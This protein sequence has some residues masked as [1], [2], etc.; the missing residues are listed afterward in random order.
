[1]PT[2]EFLKK[3]LSTAGAQAKPLASSAA[4][5]IL[6]SAVAGTAGY[7]AAPSLSDWA[8]IETEPG[9]LANR[10]GTAAAWASAASPA[11]RSS[12][13]TKN[14]AKGVLK[15]MER[16]GKTVEELREIA[17]G[18]DRKLA[19][20]K[21]TLTSAGLVTAP[22]TLGH[23]TDVGKRFA[24]TVDKT[25]K[26]DPMIFDPNT[27]T[28]RLIDKG[29]NVAE[30]Y[31]PSA[32]TI[33]GSG[34]GSG[35]GAGAAKLFAQMLLP[36]GHGNLDQMDEKEYYQRRRRERIHSLAGLAGLVAGGRLGGHLGSLYAPRLGAAAIE[37]Y[38]PLLKSSAVSE[39]AAKAAFDSKGVKDKANQL[40]KAVWGRTKEVGSRLAN[41]S[42]PQAMV[43]GS[44]VGSGLGYLRHSAREL[45]DPAETTEDRDRRRSAAMLNGAMFGGGAA[46]AR[47]GLKRLRDHDESVKAIEDNTKELSQRLTSVKA[48][49]EAARQGQKPSWAVDFERIKPTIWPWELARA[50]GVYDYRPKSQ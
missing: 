45:I 10:L 36:V 11:V 9:R 27:Q 6:P 38:K 47:G 50:T 43:L 5:N 12:I 32:G 35:L 48:K 39:L 41:L 29:L 28:D 37:K 17:P 40:G 31:M 8:G 14:N 15:A 42:T 16:T 13:W 33:A 34:V 7:A 44:G 3:L 46:L 26:D 22:T 25:L 21:G 49:S 18:I 23:Y 4:K 1:M 20:I 24:D 19:P 2:G 30:R